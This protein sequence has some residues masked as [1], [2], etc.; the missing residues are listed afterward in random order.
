MRNWI[1]RGFYM[2]LGGFSLTYE[3]AEDFVNDLVKRGEARREETS[4]LVDRLMKRGKE[5]QDAVRKMIQEETERSMK[6]LNLATSKDVAA[7]SKKIDALSK[8]QTK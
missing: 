6:G 8:Q 5:E 1:E 2:G 3:K 7:L 4:D